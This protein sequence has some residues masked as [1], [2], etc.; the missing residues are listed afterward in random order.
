MCPDA[1]ERAV[2]E[3]IVQGKKPFFVGATGGTTVLG[4]FDDLRALRRVCDKHGMWLHSDACWGG[5]AIL[6]GKADT[7]ELM[8][9]I[10]STDSMAWNPHKL[11]GIPIQCSPFMTRH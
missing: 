5:A 2:E 3:A 10:E 9:G 6:S 11:M 1:L 7:K 4:A 8:G